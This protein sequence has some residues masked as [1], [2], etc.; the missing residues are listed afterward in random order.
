[1]AVQ[2][3]PI[4]PEQDEVV[5]EDKPI[6]ESVESALSHDAEQFLAVQASF[7]DNYLNG[8]PVAENYVRYSRAADKQAEAKALARRKAQVD[9]EDVQEEFL[10]NPYGTGE[11]IEDTAEAVR[12]ALTGINASAEDVD[13]QFTESAMGEGATLE[14]S[15][16]EAAKIK[17]QKMLSKWQEDIGAGDTLMEL[18][19]Q[20]FVPFLESARGIKATGDYFGAKEKFQSMIRSWKMDYTPEEQAAMLPQLKAELTDKVGD[21]AAIDMLTSF[22]DPSGS[23]DFDRFGGEEVVWDALD[24]TGVGYL[25]SSVLRGAGKAT[26]AVKTLRDLKNFE[27]SEEAA[28]IAVLDPEIA[29]AMNMDETTAVSNALPFDTSIE[30][31]GRTGGISNK[32]LDN[33]NKFFEEADEVS[34]KIRTS[35]GFLREQVVNNS[36]RLRLEEAAKQKFQKEKA[37]NIKVKEKTDRTTTFEYQILDE[38]GD[39]VDETY[40]M[41]FDLNDAGTFEQSTMGLI[42]EYIGSPTIF[43]KGLL[44]E[45]VKTAQRLDFLTSKINRQLTK[46][47][48]EA[49]EPIGLMPTPKTKASLARVDK[50]LR[51]G[52][53]W[54]N[55]D[56][57][58]GTVFSPDQ[59]REKFGLENENEI[60]AYYRINRLYNNLWHIRNHEKREEL[61]TLNYKNISFSRN[62]DSAIGKSYDNAL[63]ASASLNKSNTHYVYDAELDE[64]VDLR[65]VEDGFLSSAYDREKMLVRVDEGYEIGEEGGLYRYA[66]VD[67]SEVGDLPQQVLQRKVGY[68]PRIY[69]DAAYFVK[70]RTPRVVDGDK[71]IHTKNTLRFFDN[72]KDADKYVDELKASY[73]ASRMDEL[74]ELRTNPEDL[75]KREAKLREEA[76]ERYVSLT[77]REEEQLAAGVG[78]VSHGSNGLYTGARAQDDILFGL[79]G[80][81]AQRVNSFDALTRNIGNLSRYTSINQ[82]RL[83]LEQRWI[84]TANEIFKAKG[85]ESKIEKFER[86]PKTSETN[87]EVRFLNRTFDQIRDW[88]NFPTAEEQFFSNLMRGLHDFTA[89]RDYKKTARLLG[90]LRNADP[91][92]AARATAFHSLLGMWN[93]AHAW[94]QA[95]GAATSISLGF[96]KYLTQTLRNTSALTMLGYGPSNASR[97]GMLA[98]ASFWDKDELEATHKLW[99]KTGY[100]D[101]V[102][103]TA[104]HAA[105]SKGYGM[106]TAVLKRVADRGLLF[107]RQGE[108]FN[109]RMAFTTALERWKETNKTKSVVGLSDDALKTVVDD[110]NNIMLN[111]TKANRAMW[112]K[113]LPSLPTQFLQVTTKF[114]ETATGL[115]ENFGR[116]ERMRMLAGQLALYGTAGIPLSGLGYMLAT[117][118]FGMTQQ[119]IEQN[120]TM[121]KAIND[122]FW[123][124]TAYHLFGA[125]IELSSRGSL[126]RGISDF[127]DN[128]FIQESSIAD[129]FLGAFGSTGQRFYDDLMHRL[130]PMSLGT[131]SDIDWEDVGRFVV[132]NPALRTLSTYNNIEKALIMERLD[133][134]YSKSGRTIAT[135][136]NFWETLAQGLGFQPTKVAETWDIQA[137]TRALRKLPDKIQADVLREMNEFAARFPNAEYSDDDLVKYEKTVQTYMA[138]LQPDQQM[139]L[140]KN[141]QKVYTGDTQRGKAIKDYIN[142]M[143][144]N[145]ATDLETWKQTAIGTKALRLGIG[146]QEEEE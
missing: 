5:V 113:G 102:L 53:E 21:V 68:V 35:D 125:D 25:V 145:T 89:E 41:S 1:M 84:N 44:K 2:D 110:A 66:L 109:R 74:S 88:Q 80:T 48:E 12:S 122:G 55:A 3:T 127:V 81:K 95:Q 93:P 58:R 19:K 13:L 17:M 82:W 42:R 7:I 24:A 18:G 67:K 62:G 57:S 49:L 105:A 4:N 29:R 45:D 134:A 91:I 114:I 129:K 76:E 37:E 90:N 126:L 39:L 60:S 94:I 107:Y 26:N 135:G 52:D 92:A 108:L 120:P 103:Q 33:L 104:D 28:A 22:L 75:A 112:Q 138:I 8:T 59:L 9:S 30:N 79:E 83:G 47:T 132:D 99:L 133:A 128:W 36:Y 144:E 65:K 141:I 54:K 23:E 43:A 50:A 86:L 46:L 136:F 140:I 124:V 142:M 97:Y 73:I 130:R 64:V 16:T 116:V 69:E 56:D 78:E 10:I 77:D 100:E 61:A 121:F 51:E 87:P 98:K 101:S 71:T 11:S 146:T 63:T 118:V 14:N 70:E 137:R 40:T 6:E 85:I 119:D 32:T 96:G 139:R 123:G 131:L 34:K 143:V 27:A 117:E 72:K 111:M 31:I 38:N 106:T 115:N 20:F 15:E